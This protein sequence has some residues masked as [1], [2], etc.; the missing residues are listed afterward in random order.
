MADIA[1]TRKYSTFDDYWAEA[2][3]FMTSAGWTLHDDVDASNKVYKTNGSA[4][5]Y[6]YIYL[7]LTKGS[8]RINIILYL[9]WNASTHVGSVTAYSSSSYNYCPYN[10]N[11]KMALV[12]NSD[13]VA[14]INYSSIYGATA[15]FCDNLFYS[16]ITTTVSGISAGSAVEVPVV[17]SY[18]I[19]A[20]Q[21]IQIVGVDYEGRDQLTV[22]S[23]PDPTHVIVTTLP[24]DYASGAFFGASPCPAGSTTY[25]TNYNFYL[26]CYSTV[27]GTANGTTSQYA[28]LTSPIMYNYIDPDLTTGLYGLTTFYAVIQAGHGVLGWFDVGDLFKYSALATMGDVFAV[29]SD[30]NHQEQGAV[31][32]STNTTLVDSSKNWATNSLAGKYVVV[33]DGT[34]VEESRK[35]LSNTSNT[36]TVVAWYI[37]P[38]VTSIYRICDKVYRYWQNN[39]SFLQDREEL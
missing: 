5:N 14:F 34:A 22:S 3:T 7:K 32:S 27:V 29:I 10:S 26:V 28:T 21:K 35:I 24:R 38:S 2:Q 30:G 8:N 36:L 17:S 39:I 18:N 25:S 9:Y 11:Y 31:T 4:S 23:I 1:L 16:D 13:Y 12:G 19:K 15:G 20:D 33:V 37:N 6:P